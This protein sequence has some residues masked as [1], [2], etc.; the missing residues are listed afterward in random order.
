[1]ATT[2]P[3]QTIA[4]TDRWTITRT[5]ESFEFFTGYIH[6]VRDEGHVVSQWEDSERLLEHLEDDEHP[7]ADEFAVWYEAHGDTDE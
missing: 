5:S 1:M 6:E 2:R 3:T 7:L 4:S